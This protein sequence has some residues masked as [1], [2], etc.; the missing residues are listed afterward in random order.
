MGMINSW[1]ALLCL[2]QFIS[3]IDDDNN[4]RAAAAAAADDRPEDKN[5]GCQFFGDDRKWFAFN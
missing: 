1:V 4:S 5:M 2:P 3:L